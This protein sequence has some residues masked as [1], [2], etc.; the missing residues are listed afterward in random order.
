MTWEAPGCSRAVTGNAAKPAMSPTAPNGGESRDPPAASRFRSKTSGS[1]A[2]HLRSGVGGR[3]APGC[4]HVPGPQSAHDERAGPPARVQ[5]KMS[6]DRNRES[7]TGSELVER[8]SVGCAEVREHREVPHVARGQS[9]DSDPSNEVGGCGRDASDHPGR[10]E[11]GRA[12]LPDSAFRVGVEEVHLVRVN[13]ECD[14][15]ARRDAAPGV[16]ASD[17]SGLQGPEL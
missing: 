15:F 6:E 7:A 10:R 17:G 3:A 1:R 8:Q 4:E 9:A 13:R 12:L 2:V 5:Q 14:P 11:T 16:Q